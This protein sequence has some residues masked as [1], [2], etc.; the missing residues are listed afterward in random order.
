[1]NELF[2]SK[3]IQNLPV[4]YSFHEIILDE[5]GN[6]C[7]YSFIEVNSLFEEY[8]G[9]TR[10][11]VIGKTVLEV[12]PGIAKS[13]FN[14]IEYYGEIALN[15][16]TGNFTQYSEPLKRSYKVSVFSPEKLF[17]V[18]LFSDF[19]Q[20]LKAEEEVKES[21]RI[22]RNSIKEAP[23]PIMIHADD[24]EVIGISNT[25]TEISGYSHQDI[26][27][28]G[29]WTKKAYGTKQEE[30]ISFI[31]N[32]YHL[33]TKQHDG[34]FEIKAKNG[35]TYLWDFY[36]TYL[37]TL[38]D[39]RKMAMSVA[40]DIT[41]RNKLKNDLMAQKLLSEITLL[42][43][44]DGIITTDKEGNIT[45]INS[46]TETLTGWNNIDA[47]GKNIE[48]VFNIYNERTG[49]KSENIVKILT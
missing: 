1:M 27:T 6:P 23:V 14:W 42:S 7:D 12:L 13:E 15:N 19:S 49:E 45:L 16:K 32:L 34:E 36:S 8:T 30:L 20:E 35:E 18:V 25:W 38:P 31:E 22:F 47:I 40:L 9:L 11:D 21:A 44:G 41:E 3:L 24:G 46:V 43:V 28:I 10:E 37:G 5:T 26:P 4:G 48:E 33:K 17:F 29:E 2:Y 39:N